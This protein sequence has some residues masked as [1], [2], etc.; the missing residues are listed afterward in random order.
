MEYIY[1]LYIFWN[2]KEKEFVEYINQMWFSS[3]QTWYEG[4]RIKTPSTNNA[5]ESFNLV[6]K[7]EHTLRELLPLPRFFELCLQVVEK[8]SREYVNSVL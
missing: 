1:N 7:K 4:A 6:I 5:L 2:K 8:W 3:H